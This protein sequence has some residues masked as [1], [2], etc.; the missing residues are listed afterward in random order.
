MVVMEEEEQGGNKGKREE[1]GVS[2]GRRNG[3][4]Y[5]I[6]RDEGEE[7]SRRNERANERA[8]FVSFRFR[9]TRDLVGK[10]MSPFSLSVGFAPPPPWKSERN[11]EGKKGKSYVMCFRVSDQNVVTHGGRKSIKERRRNVSGPRER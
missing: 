1:T 2:A 5:P 9:G 8:S 3:G 7:N 6:D 4:E 10:K 11:G